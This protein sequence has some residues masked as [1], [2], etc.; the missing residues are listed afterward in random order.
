MASFAARPPDRS[1]PEHG[2]AMAGR[3]APNARRW[4]V[5]GRESADGRFADTGIFEDSFCVSGVELGAVVVAG[6]LDAW[7]RLSKMGCP[8]RTRHDF[9]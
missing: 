4:I 5:F 3:S 1:A 9:Q 2:A 6:Q 8:N 7:T